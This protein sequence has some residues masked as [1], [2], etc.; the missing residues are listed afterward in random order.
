MPKDKT[1]NVVAKASAKFPSVSVIVPLR[2]EEESLPELHSHLRAVLSRM[3]VKYEVIFIDDG[4]VDGSFQVLQELHNRYPAVKV[5]RFRRNFGKSA[6]LSV[7]FKEAKGDYVITMDA[8]LQDDPEEIPGLIA[9]LGNDYDLASGWKKKRFDPI[10][11]TIPSRFFNFVT[12][13]L[14]GIPIHD[15]NCGL[16]AYRREVVKE[17]N[18]YGELHRYIPALVHWAG[19]RVTERTVQHHP[20]KYGRTK[21]GVSRFFNG[22]LD[23]LTVLFT[24][25][26]IRRPLHLFGVWGMVSFVTGVAIDGYL[27]YEWFAGRTSL[28]NRPLFLVGFLFIIIGIQFVSIGLL[29]EMISR[30]QRDEE[31]YSIREMLK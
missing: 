12:A 1:N 3:K 28:S 25:H 15:F 13:K 9:A 29:G 20:R 8:D 30:Q 14:T 21:F 24:T 10:T 31:V 23:L 22:F 18:V 27:S 6:A 19:Y 5:I 7:G 4:S 16:K 2:D 11:K 26:Y 17:I